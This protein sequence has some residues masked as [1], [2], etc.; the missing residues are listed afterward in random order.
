MT[1]NKNHN[2]FMKFLLP[3]FILLIAG[4]FTACD[5]DDESDPPVEYEIIKCTTDF[6]VMYFWLNDS[7]PLHKDNFLTLTKD[8]FYD[9]T[10]FHRIVAD[11]VIQG[12]DPNSKDNDPNNDGSGGPGY[13]IPAEINTSLYLHDYGAIGAAR[14]GNSTNPERKSSGSQFYI[15]TDPNGEHGL[16]GEYTVF[17]MVIHGMNVALDIQDEPKNSSNRPTTDIKMDL[18]VVSMT[19]AELEDQFGYIVD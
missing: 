6:G 19:A 13:T 1:I 16:D 10:T 14:L 4:F 12:G 5:K 9:N 2:Q 18:D 8:D 3:F 11:F 15:V 7:T 17:G